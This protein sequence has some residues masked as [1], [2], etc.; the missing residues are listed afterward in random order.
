L[1][2]TA[3]SGGSDQ[4]YGTILAPGGAYNGEEWD[5]IVL[6]NVATQ[7]AAEQFK[8]DAPKRAAKDLLASAKASVE[9]P[10]EAEATLA[11]PRDP[12]SPAPVSPKR[13]YFTVGSTKDEVLAVQ[14]TPDRFTDSSC[15]YGTSDVFFENGRVKSWDDG[16]PK[17][18]AKLLPSAP[19]EK[20]DFFTIGSTKDEVLA[21][22]GTPNRFT[23]SSYH[24]GTSDVFFENGRVKSWDDGFPKLKARMNTRSQRS[25]QP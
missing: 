21:V 19:V 16:F 14:G 4:F 2:L 24:Y 3:K 11:K 6:L 10:K 22:Q 9:S 17:L 18:K 12:G 23:D 15:H 5:Y 25:D 13:D 7:R 1:K 8:L 20:R